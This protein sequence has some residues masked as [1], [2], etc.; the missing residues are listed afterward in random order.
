MGQRFCINADEIVV[1]QQRN[2]A[3]CEYVGEIETWYFLRGEGL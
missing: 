3:D 2:K 1:V